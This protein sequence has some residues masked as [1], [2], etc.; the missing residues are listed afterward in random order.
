MA[1]NRAEIPQPHL[2]EDQ[3]AAIAAAAIHLHPA[4]AGLE[5]DVRQRALEAFLGFVREFQGQFALGQTPH[6]ALEIPGELVIGGMGDEPVEV[7]GDGADVLGNAPFIVVE[8]AD[9]LLRR[10]R[11]VVHRFERNAVGQGGIAKD[12][13]HVFI[14]AALVAGGAD[15][16]GGGKRGAGVR[17][18]VAIVLALRAQGEP[19]QAARAANGVKAALA[20]GQQLVDVNLVAHV[21]E[22]LVLGRVED[23]MQRQRQLHHAEVRSHVPAVLGQHGDEFMPDLLGQLLQLIQRQLLDVRRAVHHLEILAH[24]GVWVLE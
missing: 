13:H 10:V 2:L 3:A 21:P 5:A 1:V 20:A 16:Q 15:A 6:E 17:R 19:A 9:E 4:R 11:D 24:D 8:D 7:G 23:V 18:A 22:K 14:A 12:R